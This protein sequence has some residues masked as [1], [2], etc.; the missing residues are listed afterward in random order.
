[1]SKEQTVVTVNKLHMFSVN[2]YF[3]PV[4]L[5]LSGISGDNFVKQ[6]IN[7]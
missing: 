5:M 4:L 6:I 3:I 1:M 2:K 7:K